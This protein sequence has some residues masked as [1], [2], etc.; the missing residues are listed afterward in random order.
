MRFERGNILLSGDTE[1]N[2]IQIDNEDFLLLP[3]NDDFETSKG[4]SSNVFI[5]NDPTEENVDRVI[6]ICKF[7]ISQ[8]RNKY[9]RRFDREIKAFKKAKRGGLRNVIQFIKDGTLEIDGE[10]FL[11]FVMEKADED[12]ASFLERNGFAFTTNQKLN[13]C[14]NILNGI[15]QLHSVGIYHRD[16]KHDNILLV[17]NEFKIGDLGLVR[18]REE[19]FSAS[20]RLNEKVGPIGWLSPEAT[21]KLLTEGKDMVFSYDCDIDAGSDIFQLGKLFWYVF[22]GNLPIGQI[23]LDDMEIDEDDIYPV[24]FHMLQ[25]KKS[26]RPNIAALEALLEPLKIKYGV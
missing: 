17:G 18:F 23:L 15:K 13:F 9:T 11:Y 24:I 7:P 4:A 21:N 14:V 26:R 5:L 1:E 3:L 16:I 19:D 10:I 25:Y 8:G 6:K 20:D 12:L 22:Q 2:F